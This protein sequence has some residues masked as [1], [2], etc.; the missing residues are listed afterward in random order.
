MSHVS[1]LEAEVVE[2]HC[3]GRLLHRRLLIGPGAAGR[4]RLV[5][6]GV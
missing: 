2:Q 6:A 3:G 4:S 1:D 5:P